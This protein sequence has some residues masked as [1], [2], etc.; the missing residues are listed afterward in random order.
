MRHAVHAPRVTT[1]V[2]VPGIAGA[3][4]PRSE[5]DRQLR[6][7]ILAARRCRA[8][9]KWAPQPIALP[10]ALLEE[11]AIGSGIGERV[12]RRRSRP[13]APD[14]WI[15]GGFVEMA[16]VHRVPPGETFGTGANVDHVGAIV[17]RQEG[18][19]MP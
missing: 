19:I 7:L 6:G 2:G 4:C 15:A 12:V 17:G 10:L 16:H 1:G 8:K 18:E 13:H 3:I 9:P 11:A 14:T 5:A